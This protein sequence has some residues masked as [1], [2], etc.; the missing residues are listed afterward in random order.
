M[1][2]KEMLKL[3]GRTGY[4]RDE[5]LLI[6]VSVLDTKT[7]WGS[8]LVE[9]TPVAGSGTKWISTSSL[10]LDDKEAA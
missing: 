3:I 2:G 6:Q 5:G 7:A 4:I 1:T 8:T 9:V 10:R